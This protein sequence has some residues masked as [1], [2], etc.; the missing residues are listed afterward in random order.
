M[1][2][3]WQI[4]LGITAAM[5]I[6]T[7]IAYWWDKRMATSGAG[8]RRIPEKKLHWLAA[9]G[10]WPGAFIGSRLTHHKTRKVKFRVISATIILL[11]VAL[12]AWLCV[13]F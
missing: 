9:L 11:H 13:T 7:F 6:A 5:S 8:G 3:F 12:L 4:Y 2:I 1:T 10:G